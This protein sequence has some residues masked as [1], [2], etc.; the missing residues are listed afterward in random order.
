MSR[1][2]RNGRQLSLIAVLAALL[3]LF[4]SVTPRSGTYEFAHL[5]IQYVW[6]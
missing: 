6:I 5:S 3:T 2:F 1:L 4:M